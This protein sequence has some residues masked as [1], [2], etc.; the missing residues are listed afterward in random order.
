MQIDTTADMLTSMRDYLLTITKPKQS[1]ERLLGKPNYLALGFIYI[2]IPICAYT[3]MYIFL[4][5]GH[6]APSVFTPWLSIPKEQLFLI[7]NR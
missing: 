3:L 4:T 1:F 6:G 2:L 5:I 7:F